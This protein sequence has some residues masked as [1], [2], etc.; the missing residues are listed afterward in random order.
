[1]R[2]AWIILI[3]LVMS[4]LSSAASLQEAQ[5]FFDNK[6]YDQAL[7]I[8]QALLK[9]YPSDPDLLYNMG[10]TALRMQDYAP[11]MLYLSRAV[12]YNPRLEDAQVNIKILEDK[13]GPKYLP[14]QSIV[15]SRGWSKFTA[16]FSS[17]EWLIL[18]IGFMIALLV[19]H[20]LRDRLSTSQYQGYAFILISLVLISLLASW[21]LYR[22]AQSQSEAVIMPASPTLY[23]DSGHKQILKKALVSG[24]KCTILSSSENDM[25]IQLPSGETAHISSTDVERI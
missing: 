8:Y 2:H 1:M 21:S 18:V 19:T 13:L 22:R 17:N 12:K 23:T 15:W 24:Q 9:Q 10:T 5:T 25:L 4:G 14:M 20:Y 6:N 3:S 16:L 7:S 11:A